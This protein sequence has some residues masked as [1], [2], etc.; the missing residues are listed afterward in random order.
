MHHPQLLAQLIDA[1]GPR[2]FVALLGAG[3]AEPQL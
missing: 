3:P 1:H 2:K